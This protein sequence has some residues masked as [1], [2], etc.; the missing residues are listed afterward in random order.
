[1]VG[2]AV[3]APERSLASPGRHG[4][5]R[6]IRLLVALLIVLGILVVVDRVAVRVAES[7]IAA[8]VQD[9]QSLTG[10]PD[11]AILGFPFLT[12]VLRGRYKQATAT[13]SGLERDGLRLT[14]IRIDAEGVR[15]DL[16]DLLSGTV[17]TVPVDHASGSVLVSYED[18][19]AY[20]ATRV[21]V[22]KVTVKR[23]NSAVKVTGSVEIPVLGR[24]LSLSGDARVDVDGENVTIR[25][26]AVEAV[27]GFLPGFA[28]APAREAL[29]V[30]FAIRGLPFGV[31]LE[32]AEVTEDGVLFTAKADGVTLD[33]RQVNGMRGMPG[34]G[35]AL[36]LP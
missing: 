11:V 3:T 19:N 29:T 5:R 20:L 4:P 10:R 14:E 2:C 24:S 26:T 16:G 32:S 1:M 34:L 17:D 35:S 8:R 15:V 31:E 13:V 28:E 33:T 12:Q 23:A 18:L 7:Q 30:R 22:P 36:Q 6:G 9:S 27:T 25:P 21:Q